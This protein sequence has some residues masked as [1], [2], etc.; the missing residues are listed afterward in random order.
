MQSRYIFCKEY[1]ARVTK[2]QRKN[3]GIVKSKVSMK[4]HMYLLNLCIYSSGE[5]EVLWGIIV[6]L[7][8]KAKISCVGIII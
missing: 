7:I 3:A 5:N 8:R 6:I 2:I 1:I 4:L